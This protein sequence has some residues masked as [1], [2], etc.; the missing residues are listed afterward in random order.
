MKMGEMEEEVFFVNAL[1]VE[2]LDSDEELEAEIARTEAA[3]D[4]CFRRRA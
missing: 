2:E 4:N 3:I 1:W